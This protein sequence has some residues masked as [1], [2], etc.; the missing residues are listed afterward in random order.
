[1]AYDLSM[2]MKVDF[3][4]I[5]NVGKN[6]KG[7]FITWVTN[8]LFKPFTMYGIAVFFF[9]GLFKSII[10]TDLAKDISCGGGTSR[11]SSVYRDV[12]V[13]S[14]LTKGTRPIRGSGC[15]QRTSSPDSVYAHRRLFIWVSAGLLYR[16]IRCF[17]R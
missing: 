13:W 12:F 14:H 4:S 17:C 11:R 3:T 10:P 15:Y 9:Y 5:K 16:G 8:W 7:L 1:L 6:P 2:M